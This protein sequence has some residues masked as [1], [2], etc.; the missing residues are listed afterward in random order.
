MAS[1]LELK[2]VSKSFGGVRAVNNLSIAFAQG[3]ITA[4]IGPNGAGKTTA[5]NLIGGLIR[6]D[7]GT[8]TFEGK[9][10][11]GKKPW[12]ITSHS[13]GRLFQDVRL[14]KRMTVLEN[15]MTAI[16]QQKS[17]SV[18]QALCAPWT[19][20]KLEKDRQERTMELI[21]M[22]DLADKANSLAENLSYGQQKFVAIAR[23]LAADAK[24]LLLDEPASGVNP[25]I[26]PKLLE[27]IKAQATQN[28][29]IIFIEHNLDIVRNLA[30]RVVFMATGKMIMSGSPQEVLAHSDVRTAYTGTMK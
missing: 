14:F 23:L 18:W 9:P 19:E 6:P 4:L 8:V 2:Q 22:F 7:E 30:D 12:E 11:S 3:K 20:W 25:A 13:I 10:I 1:I 26:V 16:K 29:T 5:F 15:V 27:T 24:M 17:E 21:E 28:R